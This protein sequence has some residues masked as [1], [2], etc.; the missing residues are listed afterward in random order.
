[1]IK[2]QAKFRPGSS[3]GGQQTAEHPDMRVN[4]VAATTFAKNIRKSL[5]E[6]VSVAERDA[7][8][9]IS[10][11]PPEE[12]KMGVYAN[13]VSYQQAKDSFNRELEQTINVIMGVA[14]RAQSKH[15]WPS[16]KGG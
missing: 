5:P 4:L 13:P 3:S 10:F 7:Y 15:S 8:L 9:E 12:A 1:M 11:R 16:Q 14:K 2:D 6:G